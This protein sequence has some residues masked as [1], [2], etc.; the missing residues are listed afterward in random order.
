MLEKL[1]TTFTDMS[2]L[3]ITYVCKAVY[4]VAHAL[5]NLEHCKDESG[6]FENEKCVTLPNS[7]LGQYNTH[8]Q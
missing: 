7:S 8:G 1:N 2:Q 4:A 3:R 6:P 5:H